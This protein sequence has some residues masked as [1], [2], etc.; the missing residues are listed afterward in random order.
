M[1]ID[2]N[3]L[4]LR[5]ELI[6]LQSYSASFHYPNMVHWNIHF[7]WVVSIRRIT[8]SVARVTHSKF[9]CKGGLAQLKADVLQ[10]FDLYSL[11]R[12]SLKCCIYEWFHLNGIA[13]WSHPFRSS[14]LKAESCWKSG[15]IYIRVQ[16]IISSSKRTSNW[17]VRTVIVR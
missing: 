12:I 14:T 2:I 9:T 17:T 8:L 1:R 6:N 5:R 11:S 10:L 15:G 16:K 13:Q 4:I 7:I 3:A